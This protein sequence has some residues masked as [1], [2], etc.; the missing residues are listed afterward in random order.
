MPLLRIPD[1]YGG[2][3]REVEVANTAVEQFANRLRKNVKERRKWAQREGVACYRIYDAD[4][5][6]YC[7]AIDWYQVVEPVADGASVEA[8]EACL[9]IAEYRA[10][11]TIDEAVAAER[12]QDLVTVAAALLAIPRERVF[13]KER[14][15]A[16]GGSQYAQKGEPFAFLTE[17]YGHRFL[18]DMGGYLDTGL[19]L[20]HRVTRRMLGGMAE[21]KRFLNLF[22][23]TGSATVHAAA[24]GATH[25]TTVDLS[26]TYLDW[27][28]RNMVLNG[29]DG[30]EHTFE[31]GDTL[32][33]LEQATH[34]GRGFD[35]VFADPP[36][37]SNS[38]AMGKRTW[39]VQRDHVALLQAIYR[40]LAPKGICVFSNNLR[41]FK[42]DEDACRAAGLALR[43]ITDETIPK[44]FAR[45][46][47]IHKC[48]IMVRA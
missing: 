34:E 3:E 33:W 6:E 23:Y 1:I 46:P 44:D 5:P 41:S 13:C 40:V 25:T 37:F 9:H 38:K 45:N 47:H 28:S 12:F 30:P 16:Q 18:V 43:E 14:V 10:P 19:F 2:P 20:D 22:A 7:A 15:Q 17:E 48:F 11:K 4:L 26:Q 42:L 36:T 29:F 24:G 35:L 32:T 27:A 21:G 8:G 39:D 31:R